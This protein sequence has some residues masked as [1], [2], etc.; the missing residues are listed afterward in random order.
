MIN[1]LINEMF[2]VNGFD[3]SLTTKVTKDDKHLS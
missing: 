1:Y 3:Y 2:S